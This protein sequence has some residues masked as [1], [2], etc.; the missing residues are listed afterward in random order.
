L[1]SANWFPSGN[2]NLNL[3]L[4]FKGR[5]KETATLVWRKDANEWTLLTRSLERRRP[6]LLEI[7]E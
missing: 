5:A 2:L 7:P 3:G 1:F 4:D 6:E